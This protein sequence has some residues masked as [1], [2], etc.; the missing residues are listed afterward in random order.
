MAEL[1]DGLLRAM[2]SLPAPPPPIPVAADTEQRDRLAGHLRTELKRR[3]FPA[4]APGGMGFGLSE[5]DI[6]N[7]VIAFLRPCACYPDP[8]D[9][10]DEC[11]QYASAFPDAE[12]TDRA[13]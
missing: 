11:P 12:E 13:R 5:Y 1:Y 9:H 3:T 10:E 4:L 6:A 7:L 8:F 2:V